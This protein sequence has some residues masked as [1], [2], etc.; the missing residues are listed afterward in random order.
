VT[1][2]TWATWLTSYANCARHICVTYAPDSRQMHVTS[3]NP[4]QML[5]APA[6][7]GPGNN[8]C[9]TFGPLYMLRQTL[10]S[11]GLT[12]NLRSILKLV[13]ET[14]SYMYI[15][16]QHRRVRLEQI[17]VFNSV[18]SRRKQKSKFICW[19]RKLLDPGSR[20][21]APE[22]LVR[23]DFVNATCQTNQFQSRPE[24]LFMIILIPDMQ[25]HFPQVPSPLCDEHCGGSC[26]F[27]E[28][29]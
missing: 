15:T 4:T 8:G 24:S 18:F 26:V 28:C 3:A 6:V 19:N 1:H 13:D 14:R 16:R 27:R 23:W 5:R 12:S 25:G 10:E 9:Y 22:W 2:D 20:L 17:Y 21:K 29:L 11:S 7:R